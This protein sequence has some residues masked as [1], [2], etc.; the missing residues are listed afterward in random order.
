MN[1]ECRAGD[2]GVRLGDLRRGFKIKD[3]PAEK[4]GVK[5]TQVLKQD[6]EYWRTLQSLA[7]I[8]PFDEHG[9]SLA[10][11]TMTRRG[12]DSY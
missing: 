10:Q 8:R 11:F 1:L 2:A 4:A 7:D 6:G 9:R 12:S 3:R 5:F